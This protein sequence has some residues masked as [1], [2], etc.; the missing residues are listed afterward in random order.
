MANDLVMDGHCSLGVGKLRL[1]KLLI[2]GVD[3]LN[4]RLLP[5]YAGQQL[6]VQHSLTDSG[7]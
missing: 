3:A 4:D 1:S 7:G 6:E 2:T 5:F